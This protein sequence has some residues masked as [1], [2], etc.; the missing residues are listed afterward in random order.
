[1]IFLFTAS[2]IYNTFL[3]ASTLSEID[4]RLIFHQGM[5]SEAE[6]VKILNV[7]EYSD[8]DLLLAY[9]GIAQTMMANHVFWPVTKFNH[10]SEG[11][12]KIEAA[13]KSAPNNPELRY[14]RLMVQLNAPS[15]LGYSHNIQEDIEQLDQYLVTY[16]LENHWKLVFVS[17]LIGC[18]K[19]H[20]KDKL[21]LNE[22]KQQL[23]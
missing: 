8:R 6:L 11:R 20:E 22:I 3:D 17:N 12:H 15:F 13:I 14:I 4:I 7:T 16:N 9:Q 23:I 2:L 19:L 10:F 18:K 21:L 5:T 1:M